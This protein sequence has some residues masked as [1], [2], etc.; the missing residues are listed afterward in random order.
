M[1]I[2]ANKLHSTAEFDD[3][4]YDEPEAKLNAFS[5]PEYLFILGNSF[6]EA[7]SYRGSQPVC[8]NNF[9]IGRLEENEQWLMEICEYH[10]LCITFFS[11][12]HQHRVSWRHL[13]SHHSYQL[14]IVITRSSTLDRVL[15]T[16]RYQ[17]ADRDME[18]LLISSMVRFQ[19]TKFLVLGYEVVTHRYCR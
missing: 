6:A 10:D 9:G 5:P 16:R 17:S 14:D 13:R 3:V 1:G 19:P 2:Y 8:I 11:V 4:F 18:H 12:E 7:V 15:D